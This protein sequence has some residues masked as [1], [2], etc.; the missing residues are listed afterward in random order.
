MFYSSQ[1]AVKRCCDVVVVTALLILL[2]P[3]MLVIAALI[4]FADFGPVFFL[5]P[6]VGK[7]E[8][9]FRVMKFRTMIVGADRFV[10]AAGRVTVANR[11]TPV[12]R[13]LRG[14]SL[15][16]LPQLINVIKGEMSLV[17]PRPL[18]L[19]HRQKLN[20]TQKQRFLMRPGITGLAQ[21]KG[22]NTL[23][24]SARLEYDCEYVR[25]YTLWLDLA[26]LLKT[27][28]V[29]LTQDGVVLDRNPDDVNDLAGESRRPSEIVSTRSVKNW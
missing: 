10:D 20:I 21:I 23:K 11:V 15:D 1:L 5:H 12:G 28:P 14:L 9:V 17:G 24:W 22:R 8:R 19:E 13:V 4:R 7:D 3:V 16:E 25:D 26:I 29:V 6:R 2:A 27:V 18:A